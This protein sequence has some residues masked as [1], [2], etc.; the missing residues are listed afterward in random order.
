[1][2][3]VFMPL[4][5]GPLHRAAPGAAKG[6]VSRTVHASSNPRAHMGAPGAW[7]LRHR[8]FVVQRFDTY[9]AIVPVL[10]SIECMTCLYAWAKCGRHGIW[11][12][13]HRAR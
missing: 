3:T 5:R 9:P 4:P 1:M 6:P 10:D 2:P 11:G 7:T 12:D 8:A 13:D